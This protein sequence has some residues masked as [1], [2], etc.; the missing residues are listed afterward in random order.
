MRIHIIMLEIATHILQERFDNMLSPYKRNQIYDVLI[1]PIIANNHNKGI[2]SIYLEKGKIYSTQK[3]YGNLDPD[4]SDFSIDFYEIIYSEALKDNSILEGIYLKD[5]EFAGD[6]MNSFN[7]IAKQILGSDTSSHK[8]IAEAD[9]PK[10][11]LEYKNFYHCLANF[12]LLPRDMGRTLKGDLNK[13]QQPVSDY[14]DLFLKAVQIDFNTSRSYFQ[15]FECFPYFLEKQF[16]IGAYVSKEFQVL[17]Y[18]HEKSLFPI[19]AQKRIQS[20]AKVLAQSK[21]ALELWD[22]FNELNI[23]KND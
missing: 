22:Y 17:E 18:S 3:Y 4:M 23:I 21:Y 11:L 12:W 8:T 9:W 13:A 2:K 5:A 15:V 19:E 10:Q 20:R 6:T 1:T 7:T 16:L 14:M